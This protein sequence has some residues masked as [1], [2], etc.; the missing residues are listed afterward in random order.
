MHLSALIGQALTRRGRAVVAVLIFGAA[1]V[2]S[3]AQAQQM[4][5]SVYSDFTMHGATF[6][7]WRV[8]GS[9]SV[10]DHS[11]GCAHW[12]YITGVTLNSPSR[13]GSSTASG[14]SA[15][16]NLLFSAEVGNWSV[17]TTGSYSCGCIKGGTA[18]Y[19][20][21]KGVKINI[22]SYRR[23]QPAPVCSWDPYGPGCP[24]L[25]G[26]IHNTVGCST[27]YKVCGDLVFGG[28]CTFA[29]AVCVGQTGTAGLLCDG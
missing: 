14:L 10:M 9:T 27:P 23:L 3:E 19:G 18:M 2:V 25:C 13:S 8:T 24:G 6:A 21:W 28:S 26:A 5:F 17:S 22:S 12:G 4:S 16:T 1:P 11:T 29:R 20:G 7:Q 15:S